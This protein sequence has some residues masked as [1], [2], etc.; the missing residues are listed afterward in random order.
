[1]LARSSLITRLIFIAVRRDSQHIHT[2][3]QPCH[4][5]ARAG[6]ATRIC[7]GLKHSLLSRMGGLWYSVRPILLADPKARM[8]DGD[9]WLLRYTFGVDFKVQHTKS[10]STFDL[11]AT[12]TP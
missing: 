7:V 4:S 6:S 11:Q 10:S 3:P 5:S 8:Q 2:H 1:M 12:I 9:H